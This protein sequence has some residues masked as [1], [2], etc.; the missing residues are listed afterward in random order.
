[1]PSPD[2]TKIVACVKHHFDYWSFPAWLADA[3]RERYPAANVVHLPDYTRLGEEI[4]DADIFVGFS[5][6][7]E[8]F[9]RAKKLKWIHSTSAGVHQFIRA[10]ILH[11]DVVITNAGEILTTPMAEHILG[12]VLA[13]ARRFP[14]AARYQAEKTWA[15]QT[16]WDESPR[17]MEISG[18]TLVI[19]GYGAIGRALARRAQA[20]EMRVLGI[21]RNPSNGREHAD[22]VYP[23][24]RLLDVLPLGDFVVLAVPVTPDTE[25][26]FGREQFATMK[27]TAYFINVGR[28]TLIHTESLIKSLE[29]GEIAGAALDVTEQEPLPPEHPLWTAPNLFITPHLS[30]VSERLWERHRDLLF[31]N[32]GR[33][34]AGKPL[35]NQVDKQRGY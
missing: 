7:P 28:G 31:E 3:V 5:L 32:L 9:A 35:L 26:A 21:K 14:S 8:Q 25:G 33:W 34:F 29:Q 24:A 17:P 6:R 12:L 1:M 19:A 11:S 16:I 18:K 20:M 30:A 13:L 27:K 2:K 23:A 15:Q 22:E 10:D 4:A